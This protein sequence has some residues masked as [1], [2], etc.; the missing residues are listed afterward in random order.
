MLAHHTDDTVSLSR[1]FT[2]LEGVF[3]KIGKG[4]AL[5]HNRIGKILLC[6]FFISTSPSSWADK[7]NSSAGFLDFNLYPYLSDV[8][9]DNVFT[10]NIA[11]TLPGR[12]SYFSLLNIGNVDSSSEFEDTATY[13]T[14]QSIRWKISETSPLDL[15]MQLNFRSGEDNDRHRLG[16][17]W[18]LNDTPYLSNALNKLNLRYAV[19]LHAIQFDHED[20]HVWQLEHSFRL[21]F[22]YLSDRLYLAGFIDHTFNQ[23]LPPQFPS[24]PIVAEA[25]LGYRLYENLFLVSEYRLNEYRRSDVNNLSVGIQYKVVW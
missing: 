9:S 4:R 22:P 23:D 18:R 11:A 8:E 16:V 2:T 14:E 15:T 7:K 24:S 3:N 20:P 13:Y 6:L 17:R 5:M 12:F 1:F 19:N 25:Q 10:L 21:G